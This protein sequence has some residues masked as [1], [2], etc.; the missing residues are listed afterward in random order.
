MHLFELTISSLGYGDDSY[1]NRINEC[2]TNLDNQKMKNH[3]KKPRNAIG[4]HKGTQIRATKV[5][6]TEQK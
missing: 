4:S 2:C 6:Q 1:N 3:G 5:K